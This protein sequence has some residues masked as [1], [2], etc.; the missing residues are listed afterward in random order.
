MIKHQDNITH[1]NYIEI[2]SY[3]STKHTSLKHAIRR[4]PC[5]HKHVFIVA[6][7]IDEITCTT[8]KEEAQP[9]TKEISIL[10]L[11]MLTLK[12]QTW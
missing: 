3:L 10:S 7:V 12:L 4:H 2:Y 6:H 1:G 9:R 11:N 5:K 8:R